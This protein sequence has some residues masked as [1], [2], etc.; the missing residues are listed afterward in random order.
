MIEIESFAIYETNEMKRFDGD[1]SSMYAK[2][3]FL[4]LLLALTV[5]QNVPNITTV[6]TFRLIQFLH[7]KMG[8]QQI[9]ILLLS[10]Y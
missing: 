6:K 3:D 5:N 7:A 9:Y 4:F 8:C 10:I 1:H 2:Y